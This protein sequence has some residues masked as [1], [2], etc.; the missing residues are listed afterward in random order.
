MR[1]LE[2]VVIVRLWFPQTKDDPRYPLHLL[3]LRGVQRKRDFDVIVGLSRNLER[4]TRATEFGQAQAELANV[5]F[6]V[7][8]NV[9]PS[10]IRHLELLL[11][12]QVRTLYFVGIGFPCVRFLVTKPELVVVTGGRGGY[13]WCVK[14]HNLGLA[15]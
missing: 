1:L 5:T 11:N 10:T 3:E 7:T 6:I 4:K 12:Y 9:A 14:S 2:R 15:L 13:G 8:L